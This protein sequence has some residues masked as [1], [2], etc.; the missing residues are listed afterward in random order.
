MSLK[1]HAISV[2]AILTPDEAA[3]N[4]SMKGKV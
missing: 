3:F 2:A 1:A 4:R